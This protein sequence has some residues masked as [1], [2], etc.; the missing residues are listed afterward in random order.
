MV[1]GDI[2]LSFVLKLMRTSRAPELERDH[3]HAQPRSEDAPG[4]SSNLQT[5][6][7]CARQESTD[8]QHYGG[9][10]S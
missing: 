9:L 4:G 2:F 3:I 10:S 8:Q 6:V 7:M 1:K 5:R